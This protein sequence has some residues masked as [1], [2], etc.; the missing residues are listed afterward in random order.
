MF[1]PRSVASLSPRPA[2]TDPPAQRVRVWNLEERPSRFVTSDAKKTVTKS[3]EVKK[4][5]TTVPRIRKLSPNWQSCFRAGR[6]V[7]ERQ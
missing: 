4:K 6:T 7:A 3:A 1:Y 5:L 2:S